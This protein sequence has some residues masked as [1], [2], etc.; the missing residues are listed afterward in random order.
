MLIK[1]L[2][3]ETEMKRKIHKMT[4]K[5]VYFIWHSLPVLVC[6][7]EK[8]HNIFALGTIKSYIRVCPIKS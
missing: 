6:I 4:K 1:I 8:E 3:L 2:L 5:F 7:T